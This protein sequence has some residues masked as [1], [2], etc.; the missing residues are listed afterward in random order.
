MLI[1]QKRKSENSI[2]ALK[3]PGNRGLLHHTSELP[4][5]LN[6]HFA[7]VGPK[8]VSEIPLLHKHFSNYLP[9]PSIL[10]SFAF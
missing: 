8:L 6:N 2:T 5:I 3:H 7:S 9:E 1:I 4:N 10:G